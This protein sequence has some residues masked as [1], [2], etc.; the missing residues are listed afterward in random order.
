MATVKMFEIK[1]HGRLASVRV[2]TIETHVSQAES[3]A[4]VVLAVD[5]FQFPV[6]LARAVERMA[7][8]IEAGQL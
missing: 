6:G 3:M 7:K 1:H 2:D 8:R 4:L 5:P